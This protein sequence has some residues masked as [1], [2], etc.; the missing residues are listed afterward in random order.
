[1][2]KK[3]E[4]NIFSRNIVWYF[5]AFLLTLLILMISMAIDGMFPFGDNSVLK[6]DLE[7]QY[8]DIYA[9]F[10]NALHSGEGLFYSFSKSL[11][12][13]M[14]GV[15]SLYLG[16][17]VNLLIYFFDVEDIPVFLTLAT[18]LKLCLGAF[19]ASIFITR[20]FEIKSRIIVLICSVA[21][22]LFEYN[23]AFCSNLHF[24]DA[25]Y[26]LPL[27]ALGVW[28]LV[29]FRKSPFYM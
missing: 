27:A 14:F 26:M 8:I 23:V 25:V 9:W 22:A 12:G 6:W 16:S 7:I 15:F 1:M 17:P 13:N 5:A 11:G 3:R 19:T 2:R 18:V 28:Q 21:Y 4:K 24:L 10:R 20:R 29:N